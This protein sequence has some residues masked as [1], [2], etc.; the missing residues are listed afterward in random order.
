MANKNLTYQQKAYEYVKDQILRI[1][2]KPGEYITDSSV[3]AELD[4][5]RTPVREAFRRL[6]RE[7]LLVYEAHRGWKVYALSLKDI[8]EIFDLKVAIEGMVARRA[9]HCTDKTLRD[10][11][12]ATIQ[13]MRLAA[14]AHDVKAW[15]DIDP[16]LH[17]IIFNM[18]GNQR[19]ERIIE[20]LNDQYHRVRI[21]FVARTERM[22][23]SIKEHE[24]VVEAILSNDPEEAEASMKMHQ[25]LLRDELVGLL[26]SLVLPFVTEGV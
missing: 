22:Q 1:G 19:A 8:N 24:V 20:N 3:A 12:S 7:G 14:D 10:N 23:R 25:N 15:M 21:G 16:I 2:F 13:K 17:G 4:I 5:S 9:A 18:A 11:L 26:E 6:E